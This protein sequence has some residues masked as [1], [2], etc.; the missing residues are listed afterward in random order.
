M[1]GRAYKIQQTRLQLQ[2]ST[3]KGLHS[4]RRKEYKH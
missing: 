1:I 2:H 4:R 3:V